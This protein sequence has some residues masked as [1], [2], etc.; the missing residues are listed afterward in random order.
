MNIKN[1]NDKKVLKP[2]KRVLIDNS[3]F[4]E[5][6]DRIKFKTKYSVKV[7]TE[8]LIQNCVEDIQENL[9]IGKGRFVRKKVKLIIDEGG[10]SQ[11]E[12]SFDTNTRLIEEQSASLP[13][14]VTFLQNETGLT[15]STIVSILLKSNRLEA[16]KK[17]PQAYIEFVLDVIRRKK[18]ALLVDGIKYERLE[19]DVWCQEL[20][21]SQELK[22]YLNS[23]LLESSKSPYDYVIYDSDIEKEIAKKLEDSANVKVYAKL[24]SW[25]IIDTPLGSYNPDWVLVWEQD[26]EQKL[27]FVVETKGKNILEELTLSEQQKIRC[28]KEHF[29]A[30][31]TGVEMLAPVKDFENL[32]KR[33]SAR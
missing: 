10:V 29:K 24:P 1:A 30:I 12:Q 20:F 27:Y 26:D 15:R 19:G 17:N 2:N 28:G 3:D 21:E 13:D 4:K 32:T 8:T 22:G 33:I 9:L 7:D 16:F 14:I 31:D 11:N 5:L 25:F 6:W 18:I 23:N